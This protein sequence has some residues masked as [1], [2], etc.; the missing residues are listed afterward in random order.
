VIHQ[1]I[2][3]IFYGSNERRVAQLTEPVDKEV[4]SAK[5]GELI[6]RFDVDNK[7]LNSHSESIT[8]MKEVIVRFTVLQETSS[9]LLETSVQT[10]KDQ[11]AAMKDQQSAMASIDKR[12]DALETQ[13]VKLTEVH[14]TELDDKKEPFWSTKGGQWIIMGSVGIVVVLT[15]AAIGHSVD[16]EFL[17]KL[18]GK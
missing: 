9:K 1:A 11:Q 3:F 18:F 12:V 14:M 2:G 8:D 4:C 6:R 5:H 10:M 15:F 13:R 7:R 16:P 17:A